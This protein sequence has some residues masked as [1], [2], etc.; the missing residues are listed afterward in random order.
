[1]GLIKSFKRKIFPISLLKGV[2]KTVESEISQL[3]S[4]QIKMM[5]DKPKGIKHKQ[6][7]VNKVD[8]FIQKNQIKV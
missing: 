7:T 1:M 3:L 2:V 8:L 5:G 6:N 4:L